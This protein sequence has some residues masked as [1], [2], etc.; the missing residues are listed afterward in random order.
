VPENAGRVANLANG[1]S[2]LAPEPSFQDLELMKGRGIVINSIA[3]PASTYGYI[4]FKRADGPMNN[5]D[6]RRALAFAMD[7]SLVVQNVWAGQGAPGQVFMR[8]ELWVFD[9]AYQPFPAKPDLEKA[10]EHLQKSGRA[11]DKIVLTTSSDEALQGSAVVIQASAKAAG[12]NVEIAQIERAAFAA[13]LA[14]EDWDIVLT[15]SYTGSNS[16]LEADAVNSLFRTGG[17]ANF[18]RYSRPEMDQEIEAA[19]FAESRDVAR[20]HYRK[21]ME[22]DADDIPVLTVAYHNYVEAVSPKVKNYQTIPLAHY[23]LRNLEIS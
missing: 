9:P 11:T 13:L 18:G 23:D 1:I 4:N 5:K 10:R 3:A 22:M 6:L 16:G 7:R 14:T 19:V 8:P 20:P 2:H 12:M 17:S 15:D 21:V